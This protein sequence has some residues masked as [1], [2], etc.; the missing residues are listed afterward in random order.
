MDL[1]KCK[2][3][4]DLGNIGCCNRVFCE[5][6]ISGHIMKIISIKHKPIPLDLGRELE[7]TIAIQNRLANEILELEEFKGYCEKIIANFVDSL[8]NEIDKYYYEINKSLMNKY[9]TTLNQLKTASSCL[10]TRDVENK[11]LE[12]FSGCSLPGDVKNVEIL[13][14]N[15]SSNDF[16]ILP[17]LSQS[18]SI[19]INLKTFESWA[20]SESISSFKI[21]QS[22]SSVFQPNNPYEIFNRSVSVAS[23]NPLKFRVLSY[24]KPGSETL[25]C[26]YSFSNKI[27]LLNIQKEEFSDFAIQSMKFPSKAA[28]SLSKD[29]KLIIT[30]GFSEFPKKNVFSVNIYEKKCQEISKMINPRFNH[31]QVSIENNIFVIGGINK[32]PIKECERYSQDKRKW[33][34]FGSL[35]VPREFPSACHMLGKIY[36][37]GGNGIETIECAAIAREKF[38]LIHL[39]LPGPGKCNIFTYEGQILLLCKQVLASISVPALIYKQ[40]G[41]TNENLFWSS[42]EYI[43]YNKKIYWVSNE[44]FINFNTETNKIEKIDSV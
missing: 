27:S 6:C 20:N 34:K 38:E 22:F 13:A 33:N 12:L 23:E 9:Q 44:Q 3:C 2:E 32:N 14:K 10:L 11:I 28:W 26:V 43:S 31:A 36:V 5:M 21:N 4:N 8:K 18:I 24:S 41:E 19:D 17:Q 30:G 7:L 16:S 25:C 40:I 37:A 35:V 15:F 42:S 1:Y 29:G 39:R